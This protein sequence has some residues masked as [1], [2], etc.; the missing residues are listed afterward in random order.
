MHAQPVVDRGEATTSAR[1]GV[2]RRGAVGLRGGLIRQSRTDG[3]HRRVLLGRARPRQVEMRRRVGITAESELGLREDGERFTVGVFREPGLVH[4]QRARVVIAPRANFG[5]GAFDDEKRVRIGI[6]PC[7]REQ[8]LG[9]MPWASGK[10]QR[11]GAASRGVIWL[12]GLCRSAP[13]D[14]RRRDAERG[15]A[16]HRPVRLTRAR[17]RW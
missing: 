9:S 5:F 2:C 14:Q 12:D 6:A 8:G 10:T 1:Q 4:E 11:I 7:G 3:E 13:P 16:H 17:T 15:R